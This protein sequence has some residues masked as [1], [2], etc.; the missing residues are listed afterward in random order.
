MDQG[1][2]R[3]SRSKVVGQGHRVKVSCLGSF[4][5][6]RLAG[7]AARRRFHCVLKMACWKLTRGH[8]SAYAHVFRGFLVTSRWIQLSG[9]YKIRQ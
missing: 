1:Q 4:V 8:C 9:I 3:S 7:G 6:H 5:P 2:D